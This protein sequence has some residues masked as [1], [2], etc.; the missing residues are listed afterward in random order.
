MVRDLWAEPTAAEDETPDA[1]ADLPAAEASVAKE[2]DVELGS[3]RLPRGSVFVL[4]LPA[5]EERFVLKSRRK[6]LAEST[7]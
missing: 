1:K 3:V 4:G 2:E 5:L 7:K 6:R